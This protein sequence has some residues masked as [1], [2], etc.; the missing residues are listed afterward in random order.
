[1]AFLSL[2]NVKKVY[3]SQAGSYTALDDVTFDLENGEFVVVL[4]PSGAGKTTLLNLLGG[5]DD[6]TAGTVT[7]DNTMVSGL[8]KKE[9]IHQA[10]A[11]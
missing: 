10:K 8:N 11:G 7:L 1:M 3:Q 5:M 4:G 6:V 2:H 9:L